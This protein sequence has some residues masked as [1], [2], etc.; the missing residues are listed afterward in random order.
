MK[1]SL[2]TPART[3]IDADHEREHR[4]ERDRLLRGR[5]PAATSGRIVAAIIGPERGVRA[6][7][8]DPRRAEDRVPE[9]AQDRGVEAGDRRQAGQLGVGHALRDQQRGQHHPGD[10]VLASQSRRYAAATRPRHHLAQRVPPPLSGLRH[11]CTLPPRRRPAHPPARVNRPPP[12]QLRGPCGPVLTWTP[13]L[14]S[15]TVVP[16]ARM[17]LK[18]RLPTVRPRRREIVPRAALTVSH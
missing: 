10:D 3:M 18:W 12:E 4:G 17:V 5:R 16:P 7:H 1:P 6:Q 11:T 8:E 13:G 14:A 2:A 9:Q 15:P